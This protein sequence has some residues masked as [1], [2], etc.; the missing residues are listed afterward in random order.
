[1]WIVTGL[2]CSVQSR[3]R[4]IHIPPCY[5]VQDKIDPT[6]LREMLES[7]KYE[8]R[9]RQYHQYFT[10]LLFLCRVCSDEGTDVP[11]TVRSLK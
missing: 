2:L 11:L 9:L 4:L 3:E 7:L 5:S 6:V 10:L 1:M 8:L